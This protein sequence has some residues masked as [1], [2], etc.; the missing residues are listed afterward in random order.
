MKLGNI[1]KLVT[2]EDIFHIHKILDVFVLS[3][4]AYRYYNVIFNNM[5]NVVNDYCESVSVDNIKY[6][7]VGLF[8]LKNIYGSRK[9]YF[10]L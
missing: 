1:Y 9:L 3:H 8:H 2:H 6:V 10:D 7:M 4:Y 5:V